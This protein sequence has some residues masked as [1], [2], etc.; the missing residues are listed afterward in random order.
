[1][2]RALGSSDN[3]FTLRH[4][5]L[6]YLTVE[7]DDDKEMVIESCQLINVGFRKGVTIKN[8]SIDVLPFQNDEMRALLS[9]GAKNGVHEEWIEISNHT[10]FRTIIDLNHLHVVFTKCDFVECV[11]QNK[12]N[13]ERDNSCNDFPTVDSYRR[14][15][16]FYPYRELVE[17]KVLISSD[18]YIHGYFKL[19][20]ASYIRRSVRGGFRRFNDL[21]R[22]KPIGVEKGNEV[23]R[24]SQRPV[25]QPTLVPSKSADAVAQPVS[26][27]EDLAYG[28]ENV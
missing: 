12:E 6:S 2:L 13:M 8:T 21:V 9:L 27:Q 14:G 22:R 3:P 24:A 28:M 17:F 4:S 16:E 23:V 20:D 5:T 18:E 1:M 15:H 10:F 26:Q 7:L 11:F 25:T 19:R